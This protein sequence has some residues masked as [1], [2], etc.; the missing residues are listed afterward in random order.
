MADLRQHLLC[1]NE[2]IPERSEPTEWWLCVL[3]VLFIFHFDTGWYRSPPHH[4]RIS[5]PLRITRKLWTKWPADNVSRLPSSQL[6]HLDHSLAIEEEWPYELLLVQLVMEQLISSPLI[7]MLPFVIQICFAGAINLMF[8]RQLGGGEKRVHIIRTVNGELRV[9]WFSRAEN[10][11]SNTNSIPFLTREAQF[12]G[13]K[14]RPHFLS[15]GPIVV[16]QYNQPL[17]NLLALASTFS[18]WLL[19]YQPICLFLPSLS[20]NAKHGAMPASDTL[21]LPNFCAWETLPGNFCSHYTHKLP[22]L[23]C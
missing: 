17:N 12:S 7:W 16:V 9:D 15:N 1:Q 4:L 21:W 3:F 10:K 14:I 22:P 13:W 6:L 11:S 18:S 5:L 2:V 23:S 19:S 20:R 8:C